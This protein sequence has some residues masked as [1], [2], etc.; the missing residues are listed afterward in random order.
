MLKIAH[1]IKT[2]VFDFDGVMVDSRRP[3]DEIFF[4]LFVGSP[5]IPHEIVADV[6][7]RNVG[8]R[9][10]IL[11]DIFVRAGAAEAQI[12]GLVDESVAQFDALVQEGIAERGLAAGARETIAGLAQKFCLYINSATPEEA[13]HTMVAGLGIGHH[14]KGVHGMP[15]A[16]NKEENLHAILGREGIEAQE[17]VVIGDGEDDWRS[18]RAVGAHF[19]AVASGFYDWKKE[20]AD[21]PVVSDITEAASAFAHLK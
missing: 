15:P 20:A 14:F 16:K 17:A 12:P 11:R 3:K 9:F 2:I 21:F 1:M 13:L 5:K 10:D 8:T 4:R 19:I 6:L 7:S 18:A